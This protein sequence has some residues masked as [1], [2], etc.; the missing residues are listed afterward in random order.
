MKLLKLLAPA[1]A[2]LLFGCGGGEEKTPDEPEVQLQLTGESSLTF[3]SAGGTQTL[4]F[5][6]SSRPSLVS[7]VSWAKATVTDFA[8]NQGTISVTAEENTATSERTASVSVV[9]G[10]ERLSVSLTQAAKEVVPDP[11]PGTDWLNEPEL[12]QNHALEVAKE[13]GLGWNLGNQMDA[14][15]SGVA[16]ETAWGNQKA[17]QATFTGLKEKGIASVRIPVTWM[18]HIGEGPDYVIED[19]WMNRVAEIVGYA[20]TAGLNAIINLHHDGAEDEYWLNIKQAAASEASYQTITAKFTAVWKQIAEKF[21]DEGD[22]LIFEAFNEIHDGQWGWG[23]NLTDGGA[24]YEIIN[25]WNQEFVNVVR[26]TGGN[27]ATRYLGIPGYCTNPELTIE[28]LVMPE[29]TA[30]DRLLVA[31]HCYDPN[32]YTLEADYDEWGHTATGSHPDH[33]E[34][35]LIAV[36]K[37]VKEKYIDNDIP[38]YF[39]ETGCVNRDTERAQAFQKYYLE[40][41]YK[42][43]TAYGIPCFLWDNGAEGTGRETSAFINHW[44]GEYMGDHQKAI[45]EAMHKA[46]TREDSSYTIESVYNSAP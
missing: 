4:G 29:D 14:H 20:K 1:L 8:S 24:Q 38:V 15:N 10:T 13:L 17:T 25:K 43:A 11:E 31:M 18:G 16:S 42:A 41:F 23:A 37:K 27:N 36:F 39:G 6:A 32:T 19:E 33:D 35:D 44:T 45:I 26:G 3:E 28:N 12:Q 2:L 21:K 40:F 5:K 9:C 34:S 22:Y 30:E 7:S 46:V